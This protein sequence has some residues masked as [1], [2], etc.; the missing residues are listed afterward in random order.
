MVMS[1]RL[2]VNEQGV[3]KIPGRPAVLGC[4]DQNSCAEQHFSLQEKPL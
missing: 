2:A 3:N 1:L 4:A